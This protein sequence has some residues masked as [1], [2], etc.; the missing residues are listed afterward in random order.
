MENEEHI[1]NSVLFNHKEL[2]YVLWRKMDGIG[3]HH[4]ECN[5]QST[6]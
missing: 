3:D 2:D 5:L 1:C 6:K 4:L